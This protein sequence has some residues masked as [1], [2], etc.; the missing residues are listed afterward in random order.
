M[1]AE[2]PHDPTLIF[3]SYFSAELLRVCV[4][5]THK[6]RYLNLVKFAINSNCNYAFPII[7]AILFSAKSVMK[8]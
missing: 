5:N 3:S 7:I 6:N 2:I 8:V 1:V 4:I